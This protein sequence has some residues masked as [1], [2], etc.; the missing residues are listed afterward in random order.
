MKDNRR[1]DTR[2]LNDLFSAYRDAC[3]APDAS[4]NFMPRLWEG[5]EKRRRWA[6]PLWRWANGLAAAAVAASLF[7]VLLQLV[8]ANSSLASTRSYVELLAEAHESDD[9]D[10]QLA[11]LSPGQSQQNRGVGR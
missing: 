10:L 4:V 6:E 2:D 3:A 9:L 1:N 5:I 7:F 8:P 11:S